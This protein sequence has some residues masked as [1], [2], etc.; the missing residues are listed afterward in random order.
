MISRKTLTLEWIQVVS[1]KNNKVDKILV[2][3]VIRVLLLVEG[4]VESGLPFVFKGGTA[5]MVLLG[6]TRRLSIDVDIVTKVKEDLEK[7][8]DTIIQKKW[9]NKFSKQ[10]REARTEID[11]EH[12][13]FYYT[14]VHRTSQAEEY[15]L[16]D[17][18]FENSRY[19]KVSRVSI[20]SSFVQQERDPLQ[21][22]IP[23]HED[24]LGDKLTAFPPNTTGIPY[25][26]NGQ[27]QAMEIIKQLYDIGCLFETVK[28]IE[29]I[30][31]TFMAFAETELGYRKMDI[32]PAIVIQDII[33][34]AML[35]CTRGK[36]GKGDFEALQQG[37]IQ[38]KQFIFSESY[39]IE[40]AI[41]HSARAAYLAKIIDLN[42]NKI[43]RFQAPDQIKDWD[44]QP[45]FNT[46]LNKLKK[47][48]PEAFFYWYKTY[49]L[50][51]IT[52]Q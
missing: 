40:K 50:S 35:I 14:P 43:E 22:D 51:K 6:S 28:D 8:F 32:N 52:E 39:Q 47:S 2:E 24:M 17:I 45:P 29:I 23:C 41:I 46:R 34:T 1:E 38:V 48:N 5:L 13:K 3:K 16:L 30:S 37:I 26:K 7:K 25:K 15:I 31:K 20:D 49:E 33:D 27:S 44:I 9:F 19:Q 18:L 10:E 42:I 36:D 12:Y 21:V 11:L 4:L